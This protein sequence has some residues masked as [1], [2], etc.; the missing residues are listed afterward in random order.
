[1]LSLDLPLS[2]LCCTGVCDAA[3]VVQTG[4]HSSRAGSCH[5]CRCGGGLRFGFT[6]MYGVGSYDFLRSY[7][8]FSGVRY[9]NLINFSNFI[10]FTVEIT[11]LFI[12][13]KIKCS[14]KKT[15]PAN[16]IRKYKRRIG[17][18]LSASKHTNIFLTYDVLMR[19]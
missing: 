1:M 8:F 9:S 18:T 14:I 15:L 2:M 5:T 11:V 10:M 7:A 16:T 19:S 4:S 17:I 13:S 3:G 6:Y 12:F